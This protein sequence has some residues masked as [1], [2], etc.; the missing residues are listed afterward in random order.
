[1][2]D[3]LTFTIP[4]FPH[5]KKFIAHRYGLRSH[6][7]VSDLLIKARPPKSVRMLKTIIREIP[8]CINWIKA[9]TELQKKQKRWNEIQARKAQLQM[10]L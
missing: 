6:I 4:I 2:A 1:M 3:K 7:K 9:R 10:F 5:V 8:D